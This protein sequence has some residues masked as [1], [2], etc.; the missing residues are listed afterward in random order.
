MLDLEPLRVSRNTSCKFPGASDLR[1]LLTHPMTPGAKVVEPPISINSEL[2]SRHFPMAR[3]RQ[4]PA[5]QWP[6][7]E[8]AGSEVNERPLWVGS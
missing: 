4:A 6:A 2:P 8:R 3:H 7:F 5:F 1:T